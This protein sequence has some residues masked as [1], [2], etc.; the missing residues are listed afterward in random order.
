MQGRGV[1]DSVIAALEQIADE[2]DQWDVVV[3]I[4]GGGATSD[5]SD[6]DSYPLAAC[7]AQMALPV[8]TGI[9]HERDETVLDHV[10]HTHLKTPTAVGAFLIERMVEAEAR[11]E[12]L[13]QRIAHATSDRLSGEKQRIL[14]LT[15]TLPMAFRMEIS[16][17]E[18][19]L[20][21]LLHRLS[22]AIRDEMQ[23][24]IH[25]IDLLEQR[26]HGLD[27]DVML[28]RGYS[29]SL[30]DGHLVTDISSLAAGQELVTRTY[31]GEITS[32]IK[33]CKTRK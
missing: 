14:R 29:I 8:I 1:E 15:T 16:R 33:T 32:T 18:R 26:L 25:R 24:Q 31:N 30:V 28:K 23:G 2:A 11:L 19:G 27:P 6:F 4:R 13:A 10:A 3:I 20:E 21:A 22:M 7:V 5:L 9:G 12:G 17:R